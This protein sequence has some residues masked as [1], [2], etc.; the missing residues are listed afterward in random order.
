M[1]RTNK[2][3]KKVINHWPLKERQRGKKLITKKAPAKTI[4]STDKKSIKE[5]DLFPVVAIGASAGGIEAISNLLENLSPNLGMAYV[6]IQHLAP[7][8]ESTLPEL[9]ERKTKMPVHQVDDKMRLEV[10]NIYVIPPNTYLSVE[11]SRLKLSPRIK[12]DG[13]FHS[14]D[15]FLNSLAAA[16]KY[17]AIGIILSGTATDGTVGIQSIKSEGGVTFAQDASA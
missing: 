5:K 13:S 11:G 17:R 12:T 2:S 8:H 6:I 14:I 9:L 4:R 16:Y 7:N 15:F 3:T 1:K 10:N